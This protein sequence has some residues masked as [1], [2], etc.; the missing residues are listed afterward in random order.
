M[1]FLVVT[2]DGLDFCEYHAMA[3]KSVRCL[4]VFL[5]YRSR[6]LPLADAVI[7]IVTREADGLHLS[8]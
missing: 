8:N 4:D 6:R 3:G 2:L 7:E 5:K 1:K